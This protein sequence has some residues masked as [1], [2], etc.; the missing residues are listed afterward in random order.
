[1]PALND[2]VP[3]PETRVAILID[4]SSSMESLS[5]FVV[6][7]FNEQVDELKKFKDQKITTTLVF[8]DSGVDLR[9]VNVPLEDIKKLEYDEYQPNGLT[10]LDDAIGITIDKFRY[11]KDWQDENVSHL[12]IIITDGYGNQNKEYSK[13]TV[14]NM[15]KELQDKGWTFTYLGANQDIE[16][17]AR[18]YNLHAGN[19]MSFTPDAKGMKLSS[20]VTTKGLNNYM[21]SRVDNVRASTSFYSDASTEV[22]HT[23][24]LEKI[25]NIGKTIMKNDKKD[26][27]AIEEESEEKDLT[28]VV[29]EDSM[30]YDI[31]MGNESLNAGAQA[32]KLEEKK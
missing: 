23:P 26:K 4:N 31:H 16:K 27:V 3:K 11:L 30:K 13:A 17:V 24:R 10:A 1:M 22:K 8:F 28:N 9:M 32:V 19:T 29:N 5:K 6:D 12:F 18:D 25:L 14:S 15:I 2:L 7:T 20:Q 21:A